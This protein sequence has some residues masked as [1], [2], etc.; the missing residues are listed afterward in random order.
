MRPD[1]PVPRAW[2]CFEK[3][4][5]IWAA[6]SRTC[7]SIP[8]RR[9]AAKHRL[10][11]WVE[12]S[13][14]RFHPRIHQKKGFLPIIQYPQHLPLCVAY[15]SNLETPSQSFTIPIPSLAP[16][17]GSHLQRLHQICI[18]NLLQI[19]AG[20]SL[21]RLAVQSQP[22]SK[23]AWMPNVPVPLAVRL[24]RFG[25]NYTCLTTY[26]VRCGFT[27]I[28]QFWVARKYCRLVLSRE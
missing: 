11:D 15:F 17:L 27:C 24:G 13:E 8:C 5:K 22:A 6:F 18:N 20:Q 25:L 2:V 21:R 3:R 19:T 9:T 7:W 23:Q 4:S 28:L 12:S 26:A 10:L 1:R 14:G 16:S